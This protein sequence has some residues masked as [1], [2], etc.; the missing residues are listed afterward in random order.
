MTTCWVTQRID[1]VPVSVFP[2][3][4]INVRKPDTRTHVDVQS[5]SKP[6]ELIDWTCLPEIHWSR[7][8]Q[9]IHHLHSHKDNIAS[10]WLIL[11]ELIY[12]VFYFIL[13]MVVSPLV[14]H[15]HRWRGADD[16]A[17]TP[18]SVINVK[19]IYCLLKVLNAFALWKHNSHLYQI[20][21][22]ARMRYLQRED[23]K[24]RM[25]QMLVTFSFRT[26]FDT[27]V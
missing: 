4:T 11:F 7:W 9:C 27:F 14:A 6:N 3:N 17:Q 2:L 25:V 8:R 23:R 24:K 21:K 20:K 22:P 18:A 12:V 5:P 26:F 19:Q 10:V 1:L 13:L 15:L 16:Y